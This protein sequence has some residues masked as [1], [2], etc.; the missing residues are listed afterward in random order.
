ME[1]LARELRQRRLPSYLWD[2]APEDFGT[3]DLDGAFAIDVR[4]FVPRKL[5]ALRAHRTQ[6]PSGHAFAALDQELG[7]T[8]LGTE[9]FAPLNGAPDWLASVLTND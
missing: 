2:L 7:E 9:W 5:A 8:Y 3:D 4:Q 6:V 1:S